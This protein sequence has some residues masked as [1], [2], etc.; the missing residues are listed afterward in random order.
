MGSIK[1]SPTI[2]L[3]HILQALV[4]IS[5]MGG[6]AMTGYITI[7]GQFQRHDADL[8]LLKQRLDQDE[9]NESQSQARQDAFVAEMRQDLDKISGQ[10][11]DLRTLVAASKPDAPRR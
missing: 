7:Q 10:L 5:A 11:A 6:W 4:I 9:K 8:A 2:E 3:G 1:F